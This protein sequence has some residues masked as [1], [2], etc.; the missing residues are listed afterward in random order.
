MIRG[1]G[2]LC[3]LNNSTK[4]LRD[5]KIFEQLHVFIIFSSESTKKYAPTHTLQELAN[6]L[7]HGFWYFY[8]VSSNHKHKL[9]S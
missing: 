8:P 4:Y 5:P 6:Q 1:F 7:I 3:T 2:L 9:Q